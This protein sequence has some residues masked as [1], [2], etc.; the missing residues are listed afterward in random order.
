MVCQKTCGVKCS[1]ICTNC[2]ST[3]NNAQVPSQDSS[4]DDYPIADDT[5][6]ISVCY[7]SSC[8]K[9]KEIAT[10]GQPRTAKQSRKH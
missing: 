3:C 1:V 6:E 7:V 10:P 9:A 5:K 2:S 8:N 4:E